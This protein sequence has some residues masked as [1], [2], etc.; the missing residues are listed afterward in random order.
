SDRAGN[1][2][3]FTL[4]E[5]IYINRGEVAVKSNENKP[6]VSSRIKISLFWLGREPMLTKKEYFFKIG[7]AK[8]PAVIEKVVNVIDASTLAGNEKK[9]MVERN[10]VAECILKLNKAAAFDLADE[11]GVM[12]RFV[13][14]DNY[15]ITGGGIIREVL[16][17]QQKWVRDKVLLREYK[18]EKSTISTYKRAE[19][20]NQ[21]STLVLLTGEKDIGKKPI[22]KEFEKLMFEDGKIVYFLGISNVLYGV[23]ADLKEKKEK[24]DENYKKEH[25]RRLAEV[26]HIMLDA[27][28]ILVVT[29]I[30]LTQEDVEVIKTAVNTEQIEIV[31]AGENITTDVVVDLHLVNPRETEESALMVREMLQNKGIIFRPW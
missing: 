3:G 16:P 1:A 12:S 6:K 28:V 9:N 24:G 21:R 19:K 2:T 18:W 8:I 17:D 13:I 4:E 25:I 26:A 14:V 30:G 29:C 22:A 11:I 10:D 27:G 15:E 23:D 20:Y 7:T 31:W 5:Q